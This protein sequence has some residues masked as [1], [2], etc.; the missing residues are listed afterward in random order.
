MSTISPPR[1]HTTER[2]PSAAP[3]NPTTDQGGPNRIRLAAPSGMTI[4]APRVPGDDVVLTP[5]AL[6]TVAELHHRF[7]ARRRCLL[8]RRTERQA[9]LA[10]GNELGLLEETADLRADPTW[11]VAPPAPGLSR[12]TVEITCPASRAMAVN[13]LNSGADVWMADLEDATSPTW[14]NLIEAQQNLIRF[15]RDELDFTGPGGKE[16]IVGARTPTVLMRPRGWHLSEKHLLIDGRETSAS[17]TDVALYFHHCAAALIERG[18]GPYF[19]LPKLESHLEARLWNDVFCYLQ[20]RYSIPR[21]TVRA[22]VLIETLPAALEMEEILHELREHSAGLNAGRWDYLF[23]LIKTLRQTGATLP[24]RDSLTMTVPFM[25]A[26]TERLVAT[27]HRRGAHA[28]GGMAAFVPNRADERATENALRRIRADKDRDA[29]DGFDGSWVA[30]PG[31]VSVARAAF[32]GVLRGRDHQLERQRHDVLDPADLLDVDSA[33]SGAS[34]VGLR[35]NI[36]V[37][38]RYLEAWLRGQG[39]VAINNLMEDAATVEISRSQVWQWRQAGVVLDEGIAVTE[40]LVRRLVAEEAERIHSSA[41]PG[42]RPLLADAV[43]L[44]CDVALGE[45]F[46][47][48]FTLRG[49]REY[50]RG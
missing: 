45:E 5:G 18:Q 2:T 13:A 41:D 49:Y 16:Y 1:S 23:S 28:I 35:T 25:R 19:Y 43:R 14:A 26:Y 37:S 7:D 8:G 27:C 50:L 20:D 33:G 17:L 24:D 42:G 21:G 32:T 38:L 6:A 48:F 9:W 22:T 47:E 10:E 29:E 15:T 11:Q 12:R 36:A 3:E 46:E 30:H 34:L 40:P 31:L 39:A 44:F 4:T